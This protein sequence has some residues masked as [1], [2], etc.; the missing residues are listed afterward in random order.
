MAR[1]YPHHYPVGGTIQGIEEIDE[2]VLVFHSATE[3]SSGLRYTPR[4]STGK[5]SFGLPLFGS[6][7]MGGMAR[8]AGGHVLTVVALGATL[9]SAR[10]ARW[11]TPNASP[12]RGR[13]YR[14]DIGA[15]DFS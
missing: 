9:S 2:G 7:S 5:L 11:S 12:S 3:N 8:T 13:T 4:A 10:R 6:A 1:G 15:T 14:G